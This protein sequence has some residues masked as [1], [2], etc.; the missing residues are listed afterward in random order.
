MLPMRVATS[1]LVVLA[2]WLAGCE[3]TADGGGAGGGAGSGGGDGATTSSTTTGSA[4][5]GSTTTGDSTASSGSGGPYPLDCAAH[6]RCGVEVA[7]AEVTGESGCIAYPGCITPVCLTYQEA[8]EAYSPGF[9]DVLES[10]PAQMDDCP[11]SVDGFDE[12]SCDEVEEELSRIQACS[13]ADECGL[14]LE[15]TGCGCTRSLVARLDASTE[16]LDA[17]LEASDGSCIPGSTCDCP[18]TDGFACIDGT[19]TWSYVDGT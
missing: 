5:T 9:C 6:D 8:Q 1:G 10:Y 16:I 14:V 13:A 7:C 12:A 17:L 3:S 18:E 11:D 15:G 2:G 19:C 4:A